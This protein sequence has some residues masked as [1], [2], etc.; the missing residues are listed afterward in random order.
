VIGTGAMVPTWLARLAALGW[1]VLA[2]VAL[3]YV[4]V[5]LATELATV[6]ATVLV[7]LLV[8]AAALPAV[9]ALRRRGVVRSLAAA[10]VTVLV[11]VVVVAA[12]VLVAV[13]LVPSVGEIVRAVREGV[14]DLRAQLEAMGGPEVVVG[15][16][17]RLV[18]SLVELFDVDL[19]R[20]AGSAVSVGTVAILS[21]FLTY[22]LLAEGDRGWAWLM[23]PMA[24]WQ[25]EAMTSSAITGLD[26]VSGYL[27]RTATFAVVDAAVVVVVLMLLDVPL[28]GPLAALVFL[29]GFVPYL[30]AILTA[31]IVS[32][33]TLAFGGPIAMATILA[34]LVLAHLVT[35]RLLAPTPLGRAVDVHPGL[36]L[37]AI[38]TG[39]ALF[40]VLGLLALLPVVVFVLAVGGSVV[41][42]LGLGPAGG[43]TPTAARSGAPA[44]P[45]G[46][47]PLWLDRLAQWSWRGL[48]VVG[49][50]LVVIEI[51]VS[52]PGVVIPVVLAAVLA[53]TLAPLNRR[54]AGLGWS[55][56]LAAAACTVGA[57]AAVIVALGVTVAFTIEPV[58]ELVATTIDGADVT[59]LAWLVES[60]AEIGAVITA[61][62]TTLL[63]SLPSVALTLV[64]ALLLAFFFLRDGS[65][66]W[67]SAMDRL[68]GSARTRLDVAGT[69]AV[70][71]LGG[72]MIGTALISAFGAITSALI[73]V[74]LG[75]PLALPIGVLTFFGGFIPY[76]GSAVTT[77]LAVLVALAVGTTTDIV[78]MMAWTVVFNIVQGNFV[79][80]LVY[81][82]TLNLHPAVILLAIPA[83]SEIA[84][85]LGMFL[86]VPFV[87]IAVAVW[88]PLLG[89]LEEEDGGSLSARGPAPAQAPESA[90]NPDAAK[91]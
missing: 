46:A 39:A 58:R 13:A 50:V 3:G 82:S 54:V 18:G 77:G 53:A 64:L 26:R 21:T 68:E 25:A 49:L 62:A 15:A 55:H 37:L 65:R 70:G 78:V 48:V 86:I 20:L 5:A 32:L 28:V 19:L 83:G 47:A 8:T 75:L 23:R 57:T 31:T 81:G 7:A 66:L 76:I 85:V 73:M 12:A 72:Y 36:V 42:A 33:V 84:G 80:P 29:G 43:A 51:V 41:T 17:D 90:S 4:L 45:S 88:R 10:L 38:P 71:V 34:A 40:G 69:G 16:F 56:G 22:F 63:R 60:V 6:T 11:A 87:A 59:D 2:I 89:L 91:R 61:V 79:A 44:A 24:S 1:R 30:G 9:R 67:R 35:D 52:I 14:A 27:R 74:V